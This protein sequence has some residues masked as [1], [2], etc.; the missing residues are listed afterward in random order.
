MAGHSGR[1]RHDPARPHENVMRIFIAI[2][3][4]EEIRRKLGELQRD[5]RPTTTSARWVAPDSIHL[6]LKFLGEIA[7]ARLDDIDQALS[8]LTWLP[9]QVSVAGVG[10]F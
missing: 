3:V 10:F 4:P 9:F 7:E 2:E 1:A 5:L 6:T 8:G